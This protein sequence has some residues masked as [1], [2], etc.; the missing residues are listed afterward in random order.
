MMNM[1]P[2]RPP[3]AMFLTDPMMEFILQP[4]D[5]HITVIHDGKHCYGHLQFGP[6]G[7]RAFWSGNHFDDH[8]IGEFKDKTQAVK[9]VVGIG[10]EI[11]RI[12]AS[13]SP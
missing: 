12:E 3:E 10:R 8:L 4:I 13:A 9:A 11:A 7:F 2:K 6:W 5:S 1:R